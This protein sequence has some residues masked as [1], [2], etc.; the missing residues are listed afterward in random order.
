VLTIELEEL[1]PAP[2]PFKVTCAWCGETIRLNASRDIEAMCLSCYHLMLFE[3][4]RTE[5]L[6]AGPDGVSER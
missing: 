4:T 1:P 6:A 2:L 5:P 3:R